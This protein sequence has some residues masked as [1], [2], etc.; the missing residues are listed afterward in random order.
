MAGEDEVNPPDPL[1]QG[2][3]Q[4]H[5]VVGEEDHGVRPLGAGLVHRLLQPP[6]VQ[7]EGEPLGKGF[8][9]GNLDVGVARPHHRQGVGPHPVDPVGGEEGV[10]EEVVH[11][12]V[13]EELSP[14]EPKELLHPLPPQGPLPVGDHV[15]HPHEVLPP[16][17]GLAPGEEGKPGVG[18]GVPAVQDQGLTPSAS[19]RAFWSRMR[20]VRAPI[21]PMGPK[22]RASS[23]KST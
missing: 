7:G 16:H 10:A 14:E 8:G 12:V 4:L 6:L 23:T 19:T 2:G 22:V 3:V 13:G 20:A 11:D 1:R 17:H 15:V 9:V 5:P 18:P 21:P